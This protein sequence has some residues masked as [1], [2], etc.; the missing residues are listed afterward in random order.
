MK[1]VNSQ[2]VVSGFNSKNPF[3]LRSLP[4]KPGKVSGYLS[5]LKVKL[6]LG[7]VSSPCS[8]RIPNS[9]GTEYSQANSSSGVTSRN[10]PGLVAQMY[11]FPLSITCPLDIM[12]ENIFAG[13]TGWVMVRSKSVGPN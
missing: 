10:I 13:S 9:K 6:P 2:K 4:S 7:V 11:T 5:D 1:S 3:G 8:N 12:T